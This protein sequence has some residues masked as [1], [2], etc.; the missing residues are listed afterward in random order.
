[1]IARHFYTNDIL[2]PIKQV[3][4]RKH[5]SKFTGRKFIQQYIDAMWASIA[6]QAEND[7]Y[8]CWMTHS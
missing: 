5:H 4:R 1:M 8:G 3:H 2:G 7:A 6:E